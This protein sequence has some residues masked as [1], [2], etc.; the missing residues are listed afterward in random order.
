MIW[1]GYV[2]RTREMRK[3]YKILVGRPEGKRLL[4]KSRRRLE[5]IITL[6]IKYKGYEDVDWIHVAQYIKWRAV[7]NT[8]MNL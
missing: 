7:V 6:Q 1:I 3:E 8:I 2:A 5:N 4:W